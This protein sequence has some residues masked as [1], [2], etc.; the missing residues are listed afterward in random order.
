MSLSMPQ[1]NKPVVV[2]EIKSHR[3]IRSVIPRAGFWPEE[4][5][6]AFVH[7]DKTAEGFLASLGMTALLSTITCSD[8]TLPS[9]RAP[10]AWHNGRYAA[11]LLG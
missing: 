7:A 11:R 3:A 2:A 4:S 10:A 1:H 9:T 6:L 5:L 8:D